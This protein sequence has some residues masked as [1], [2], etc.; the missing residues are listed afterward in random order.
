VPLP[1]SWNDAAILK[2]QAAEKPQ[3]VLHLV[4]VPAVRQLLMQ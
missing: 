2:L 4:V 3:G 1:K